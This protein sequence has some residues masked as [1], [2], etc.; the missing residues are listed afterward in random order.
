MRE[1]KRD[2]VIEGE[3]LERH[4]GGASWRG[5]GSFRERKRGRSREV[6]EER[7]QGMF[8]S[9]LRGERSLEGEDTT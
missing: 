2:R 8:Q 9:S 4:S 1:R 7:R 3:S 6:S 5:A